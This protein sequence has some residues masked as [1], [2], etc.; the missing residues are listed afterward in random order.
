MMTLGPHFLF[1]A[2]AVSCFATLYAFPMDGFDLGL[3][4]RC[5][6]SSS[7]FIPPRQ[8]KRVEIFPADARCRQPEII[9]TR[10][11]NK[12]L[13]VDPNAPWISKVIAS[14]MN[15]K[16]GNR[17]GQKTTTDGPVKK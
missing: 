2:L 17:G 13:C 7:Q 8:M 5:L 11:D 4:C 3:K 15:R 14:V 12:V 10:T 9:I 1:T 16:K 6:K